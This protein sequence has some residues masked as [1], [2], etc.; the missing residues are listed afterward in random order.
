MPFTKYQGSDS[1]LYHRRA[2]RQAIGKS[3]L[4]ARSFLPEGDAAARRLYH[5]QSLSK[6]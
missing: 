1:A 2:Q 4:L 3:S 5:L 6:K